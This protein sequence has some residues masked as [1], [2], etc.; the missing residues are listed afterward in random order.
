[1]GDD[2]A[3]QHAQT[4]AGS[5]HVR[6]ASVGGGP[7]RHAAGSRRRAAPRAKLQ[8]AR[9][10]AA[11]NNNPAG[12]GLAR[13]AATGSGRGLQRAAGGAGAAGAAGAWRGRPWWRG[14]KSLRRKNL[15][16]DR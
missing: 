13:H 8:Q 6:H 9:P 12:H 1:M 7:A 2:A 14:E 5:G 10:R 4:A 11:R 15:V 16:E 3:T